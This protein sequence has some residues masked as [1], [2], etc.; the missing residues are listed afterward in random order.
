MQSV[1][2]DLRDELAVPEKPLIKNEIAF[3][4]TV[5]GSLPIR[6]KTNL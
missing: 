6:E 5:P 4:W 2:T 3:E 1:L